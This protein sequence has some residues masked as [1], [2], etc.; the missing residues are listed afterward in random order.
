MPTIKTQKNDDL[1]RMA[2][3]FVQNKEAIKTLDMENKE[4]RVPLEAALEKN[5]QDDPK[6]NRHLVLNTADVN[7]KLTY[8]SKNSV[9]LNSNAVEVLEKA[10][11]IHPNLSD[12]LE[13]VTVVR[14]DIVEALAQA[15]E[16]PADV[17]ASIYTAHTTKAFSVKIT[18]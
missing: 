2:V 1:T 8:T 16:I 14:E 13:T 9:S 5:G 3:K 17:L 4:L 18:K 6:G 12:C 7:V 15:G 10:I 11:E